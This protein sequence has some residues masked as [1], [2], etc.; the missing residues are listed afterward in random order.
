MA[1]TKAKNDLVEK[2]VSMHEF[3]VPEVYVE[4]QIENNIEGRL[5]TLAS[6]G[7]DVSKL[8]LDWA[9][10]KQSQREHAIGDVK[11]SLILEKIAGVESIEVTQEDLDRQV[12][13]VARQ[14]R[15]PVAAVRKR[16]TDDGSLRRI[17]GRIRTEKTLGFLFEHATKETPKEPSPKEEMPSE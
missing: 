4:Q 5:R 8:K 3:P 12:Q 7:V 9:Q 1:Q 16:L 17:A 10:L 11:A 2:L 13:Q 15:E 6:Q 14:E